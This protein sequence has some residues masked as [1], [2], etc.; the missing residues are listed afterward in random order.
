MAD[1]VTNELYSALRSVVCDPQVQDECRQAIKVRITVP[2]QRLSQKSRAD[3][4][5][6]EHCAGFWSDE[7]I[8]F[9][10]VLEMRPLSGPGVLFSRWVTP[11]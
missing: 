5:D 10:S 2:R 8:Q 7:V 3:A 4:E 1:E 6:S 9:Q 11:I